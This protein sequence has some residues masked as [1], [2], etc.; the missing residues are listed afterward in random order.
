MLQHKNPFK[1][2]SIL[3]HISTKK[4]ASREVLSC[5]KKIFIKK[6]VEQSQSINKTS[7][8]LRKLSKYDIQQLYFGTLSNANKKS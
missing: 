6:N 4:H 1:T 8:Y 2:I 7:G 5:Y 3:T